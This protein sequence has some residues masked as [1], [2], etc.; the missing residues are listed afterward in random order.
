M[1]LVVDANVVI[2]AL[3]SKGVSRKVFLLNS[4]SKR[5]ELI[6]PELLFK[7]VNKRKESLIKEV[8]ISEEEFD[9]VLRFLIKNIDFIPASEFVKFLPKANEIC[10]DPD[11]VEYVALA[12]AFDCG[13]F[14]GDPD[15]KKVEGVKAY[16]PRELL[17]ILLGKKRYKSC[18]HY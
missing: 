14:S 18:A 5:I 11:N 16:S 1:L 7:E 10:P 8:G 3:A 12:L 4:L 15:L 17:D 2:S 6:A 13:I 9:K